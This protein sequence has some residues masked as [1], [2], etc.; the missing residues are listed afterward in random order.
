M[1]LKVIPT[2]LAVTTIDNPCIPVDGFIFIWTLINHMLYACI[3]AKCCKESAQCV[4]DRRCRKIGEVA[5]QVERM[6]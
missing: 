2:K 6:E 5:K 4:I 1:Y 3:I